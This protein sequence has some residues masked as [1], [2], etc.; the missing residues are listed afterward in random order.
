MIGKLLDKLK[1]FWE[2][3]IRGEKAKGNYKVVP[4]RPGMSDFNQ[5]KDH[6]DKQDGKSII[7]NDEPLPT[8]LEPCL[9]KIEKQGNLELQ[10]WYEV[11]YY[12]PLDSCW[13]A[14]HGSNTFTDGERVVSWQRIG[15]SNG[16]IVI[17]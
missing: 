1:A 16:K 8:E 17:Y 9:A 5:I 11:V 7:P 4:M 13:K 15:E 6:W 2:V 14:Y 3:E 12:N 10:S